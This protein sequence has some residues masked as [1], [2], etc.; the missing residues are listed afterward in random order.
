VDFGRGRA[1]PELG[2]PV[3][4]VAP[5]QVRVEGQGRPAP[6]TAGDV[7]V[8]DRPHPAGAVPRFTG[9]QYRTLRNG[10]CMTLSDT[11]EMASALLPGEPVS[12]DR[13]RRFE[14]GAEPQA[15]QLRSRL[16]HLYN[17]G[18]HTCNERVAVPNYRSPFTVTFPRYWVGPVWF[19]FASDQHA[20]AEV[21]VQRRQARQRLVVVP[22]ASVTST[23]ATAGDTDPFTIT[24]PYG[25]TVTAGM[26]ARPGAPEIRL[27]TGATGNGRDGSSGHARD[28]ILGLLGQ[29]R[30]EAEP[31]LRLDA[32][33]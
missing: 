7:L 32:R 23:R 11:A 24:C 1:R 8:V 12:A 4:R 6:G 29:T 5:R 31:L 27:A 30:Q 3:H 13:I 20:S 33:A 21:V 9:A 19:A 17:A 18:G 28:D 14:R 26:G 16:D 15:R 10:R 22:G 25:W 2:I